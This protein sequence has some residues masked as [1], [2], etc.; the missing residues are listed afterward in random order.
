AYNITSYSDPTKKTR[1]NMANVYGVAFDNEYGI[2]LV[3]RDPVR[4]IK[5]ADNG[6]GFDFVKQFGSPG[7]DASKI[8]FVAPIDAAVTPDG[9]FLYVIEDGEPIS[10]KNTEPGLARIVKYK[11]AY[12]EEKEFTLNVQ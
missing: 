10:S 12:E 4:I 5:L 9:K 2:F 6:F 8:E 7:N 3:Q 11:I 1:E